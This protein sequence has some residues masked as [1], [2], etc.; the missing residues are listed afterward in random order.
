LAAWWLIG[1]GKRRFDDPIPL[2]DGRKLVTLLAL[3]PK[4]HSRIE[5][6]KLNRYSPC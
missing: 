2:P 5:N 4:S 3:M 6:R 1:A